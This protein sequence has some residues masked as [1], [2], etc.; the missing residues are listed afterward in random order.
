VAAVGKLDDFTADT[1]FLCDEGE[2]GKG[3]GPEG[4]G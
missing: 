3:A 1:I 2:G 4:F